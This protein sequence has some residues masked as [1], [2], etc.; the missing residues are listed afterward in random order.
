MSYGKVIKQAPFSSRDCRKGT[1]ILYENGISIEC[2]DEK[3]TY[4]LTL[5]GL[6]TFGKSIKSKGIRLNRRT[7]HVDEPEEWI[8][9]IQTALT[10]NCFQ[11]D[12]SGYRVYPRCH[13]WHQQR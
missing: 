7:Y 10:D 3:W 11:F 13:V 2:G 4:S 6:R 12:I 8:R 9:A 1:L 5:K